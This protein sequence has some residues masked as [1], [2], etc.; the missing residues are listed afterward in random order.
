MACLAGARETKNRSKSRTAAMI[1]I[2]S[3][4]RSIADKHDLRK[5]CECPVQVQVCLYWFAFLAFH[6]SLQAS[7]TRSPMLKFFSH[8]ICE[9][10][11]WAMA[12]GDMPKQGYHELAAQEDMG[13]VDTCQRRTGRVSW[14][15]QNCGRPAAII[16]EPGARIQ[17][18]SISDLFPTKMA[19][20]MGL[21]SC[22]GRVVLRSQDTLPL[23]ATCLFEP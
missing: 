5:K 10:S 8:G 22:G 23:S 17:V 6:G 21:G 4:H 2:I 18:G 11:S 14:C 13:P 15:K 3:R 19:R 1:F 16:M 7:L 9:K 12:A 20:G